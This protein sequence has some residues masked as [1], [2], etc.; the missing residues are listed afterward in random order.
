MLAEFNNRKAKL[1][2]EIA[3]L[4]ATVMERYGVELEMMPAHVPEGF[5]VAAS[6]ERLAYLQKQKEQFGGVNELALENYESEK[7]RLDFLTA[8]KEDLVSAEKQLRE[9][10]EE[11]NRT[12]LENSGKPSTRCGRTSSGFSTTCS[13]LKTR[14][15]CSSPPRMK[16][17]SKR[18]SRSSPSHA[19]RNR[20]PSSSLAAA[21]SADC[22]VAAV[23]DLPGQARPSASSTESMRRST[24]PTS[25]ASSSF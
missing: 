19:A 9:T 24:T 3:H 16:T 17:R 15:I 11:I 13:I 8:Q 20:W 10:I 12:A 18:T 6:R 1:E 21:K 5:D 23:C 22:P 25:G 14:L 4:Q 2:Q 7:E